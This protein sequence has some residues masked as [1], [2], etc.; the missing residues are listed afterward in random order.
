MI[1]CLEN[2]KKKGWTL[3]TLRNEAIKQC[4]SKF[5]DD[6][7]IFQER[8]LVAGL[9]GGIQIVHKLSALL[10]D[11]K[12]QSV[13]LA[14]T[15]SAMF[16]ILDDMTES[17]N[18]LINEQHRIAAITS[19]MGEGL[20]VVDKNFKISLI[21][22]MAQNLLEISE[23]EALG[24]NI[25]E[26]VRVFKGKTELLWKE[27]LLT[28][29]MNEGENYMAGIQDDVYYKTRSGKTFPVVE[30]GTSLKDSASGVVIVF[31]N[32][33]LEKAISEAKTD[34]I[35]TASH[36]L[37]T[38]L[39]SIRWSLE[40][41]ADKDLGQLSKDQEEFVNNIYQA[42]ERM[43]NVVNLLLQI[44]R[45]ESKRIKIDSIP[46]D[47]KAL[48]KKL[49]IIFQN[50]LNAK[51]IKLEMIT[52]PEQI[53]PIAMDEEVVSQVIQNILSNA[54]RYTTVN[55]IIKIK[56]AVKKNVMEF[57]VQDNGIGIPEKQQVRI[58]EK[59][60]RAD[61]ALRFVPEG[62][63]LGLALVKL[64]VN[65]WGGEIWFF[66]KDG[67]VSGGEAERGTT[68][69][70]TIPLMGMKSKGGEVRLTV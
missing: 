67:S 25:K 18:T 69:F 38:P 35:S 15:E 44:A 65:S 47:L 36:Q 42:S 10:D 33:T 45:V 64:L 4:L 37:R 14:Q 32:I 28:R 59:F 7:I 12:K 55:G 54:I 31:R 40:M 43:I 13:F 61:N 20:L 53:P 2:F 3:H 63:G 17:Q 6:F 66:S 57:S 41:L 11:F 58:F 5:A 22:L 24:K 29:V 19:S 27:S 30:V 16:N 23:E 8:Q 1:V 34:F 39:T 70:F 56:L 21:N 49:I 50:E 52:E 46:I 9:T 60:F 51:F 26:V 62:S 68:F 48:T